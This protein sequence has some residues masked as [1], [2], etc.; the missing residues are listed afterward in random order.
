MGF[1]SRE[2]GQARRQW[3]DNMSAQFADGANYYLGP[4]A[5]P[6]N[7]LM[8]VG[9]YS[10]AGDVVEARDA[11]K[12]LWDDP[13]L[14]N[15]LRYG[16]AAG[17]M[18]IPM[19]SAK[20]V[21]DGVD[22]FGDA[23]RSFGD[24]ARRFAADEY[25]G[26]G[27]NLTPAQQQSQDV[28][29]ML[30]TGRASE[31]TDDMLAGADQQYLFANYDLP[32]DEASRAGRAGEMG[33]D[34]ET[35]LYH[36]SNSDIFT[37]NTNMGAN[38]RAKTGFYTSSNPDVADTY[39]SNRDGMIYPLMGRD[40]GGLSVDAQGANWNRIPASAP[41]SNADSLLSKEFPE[42]ADEG[43]LRDNLWGV[44]DN[45]L[46]NTTNTNA[47][48]RNRRFEGDEMVRINNAVDRGPYLPSVSDNGANVPSNL[49]IDFVPH[50]IRSKFA[51]FDPRLS[52]LRSLSAGVAGMGL[53]NQYQDDESTL[54]NYLRGGS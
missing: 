5:E 22:V 36:G 30:K 8:S 42:L 49:R 19:V 11:S 45:T 18:A 54:I 3:L 16:T 12:A 26:P 52:Q 20:M 17:A 29:D 53:L 41:A 43:T 44:F 25:G 7:A 1:F 48:A 38:E 37:L 35:P 24:D 50:N 21:N 40:R 32:M 9:Q 34:T 10:D 27:A 47:I 23:A 46:D 28:L 13:S 39:A 51:R 33:F 4:A 2:S 6:L 14:G 31:V 15:A